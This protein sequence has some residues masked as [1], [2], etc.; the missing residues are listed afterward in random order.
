[1]APFPVNHRSVLDTLAELV[2]RVESSA[3]YPRVISEYFGGM[4]R[5]FESLAKVAKKGC[6]AAYVV[7]QQRTYLQTYVPT[8]ELL[9]ELAE[10]VGLAVDGIE[11]YRTRRG[12]TGSRREIL[13]EVLLLRRE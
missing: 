3:V 11:T 1:M 13:E 8:A 9:A 2:P 10:D 12:S 6:R 5:H 4:H 7:G